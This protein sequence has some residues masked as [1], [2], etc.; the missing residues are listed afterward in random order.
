MFEEFTNTKL[1]G[2]Q[3]LDPKGNVFVMRKNVS[4]PYPELSVSLLKLS[5]TSEMAPKSPF[6]LQ[7]YSMGKTFSS[8]GGMVYSRN[9]NYLLYHT[10]D[11]LIALDASYLYNKWAIGFSVNQFGYSIESI[12]YLVIPNC[13]LFVFESSTTVPYD[14]KLRKRLETPANIPYDYVGAISK[15]LD[16]IAIMQGGNYLVLDWINGKAVNK[17]PTR[18]LNTNSACNRFP[19]IRVVL[20]DSHGNCRVKPCK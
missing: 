12:S 7:Q 18:M 1:L 4:A 10:E 3:I 9:Y 17:V 16:L 14:L 5:P 19:F 8:Y 6:T 2:T 15:T 13:V 20:M 11:R